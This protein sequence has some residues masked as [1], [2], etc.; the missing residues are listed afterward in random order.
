MGC[1]NSAFFVVNVRLLEI[2]DF[3]NRRTGFKTGNEC[4]VSFTMNSSI[5]FDW[6]YFRSY[7]LN[8]MPT[9]YL[10]CLTANQEHE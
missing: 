5:I 10:M 7:R 9:P 8:V 3:I 6:W 2:F 4:G 1:V